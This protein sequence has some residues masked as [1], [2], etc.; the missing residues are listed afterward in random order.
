MPQAFIKEGSRA[1][2]FP[3]RSISRKFF[4]AL[5]VSLHDLACPSNWPASIL[6]STPSMLSDNKNGITYYVATISQTSGYEGQPEVHFCPSPLR[7]SH[8]HAPFVRSGARARG[9]DFE[10]NRV[11]PS[12][13][14][15]AIISK[16]S[17]V[18]R[19]N[20]IESWCTHNNKR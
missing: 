14:I 4:S 16:K 9:V 3:Q 10:P 19:A 7:V 13:K 12:C 2:I 20:A 8:R 15:G 1:S 18:F 6:F 11:F 17:L 5:C